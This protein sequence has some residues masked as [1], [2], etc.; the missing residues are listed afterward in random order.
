MSEMCFAF[1]TYYPRTRFSDC[2][3]KMHV[4]DFLQSM[5]VESVRL[6]EHTLP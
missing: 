6:G 3:S 2:T 4:G 5:G 1:I